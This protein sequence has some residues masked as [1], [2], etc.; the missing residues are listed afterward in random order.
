MIRHIVWWT[1]K[2][3]QGQSA[4]ENADF[5]LKASAELHGNPHIK[6]LEVAAKLDPASTVKAQLVLCALFEDMAALEA[7]KAD[8]VHQ[9]F[10]K[11]V[12]DRAESRNCIDFTFLPSN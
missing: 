7:Y 9:R 3:H 6:S 2:N 10:A 1:L 5:L 11:L 8:P 12:E 4:A